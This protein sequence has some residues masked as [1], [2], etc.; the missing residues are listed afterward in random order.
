MPYRVIT[1]F[2]FKGKLVKNNDIRDRKHNLPRGR[3][4][5]KY[6]N[7][8]FYVDSNNELVTWSDNCYKAGDVTK[9]LRQGQ[10]QTKAGQ[11][12]N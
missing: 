5:S 7:C 9:I 2:L 8:F 4:F 10:K 12:L 3:F 6:Y 1:G 11:F